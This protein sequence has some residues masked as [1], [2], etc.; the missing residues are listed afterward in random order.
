MKEKRKSIAEAR[1]RKIKAR[2][3]G[4]SEEEL[5]ALEA[6]K[7]LPQETKEEEMNKKDQE[8]ATK[9]E[10]IEATMKRAKHQRPWDRGKGMLP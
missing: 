4:L 5:V 8:V 7:E 1:L 2:K 10:E 3:L 9:V 6:S